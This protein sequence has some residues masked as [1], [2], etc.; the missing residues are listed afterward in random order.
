MIAEV[1]SDR[2]SLVSQSLAKLPHGEKL[3]IYGGSGRMCF[4]R[5]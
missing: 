5:K 3:S 2:I 1:S 4:M